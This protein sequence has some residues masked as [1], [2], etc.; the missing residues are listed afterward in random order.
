MTGKQFG[1]KRRRPAIRGSAA[2]MRRA[3]EL[4]IPTAGTWAMVPA[5]AACDRSLGQ[6]TPLHVLT[7][8]AKYRN[9][10]T[11]ECFPSIGRLARDLGVT[12][13]TIQRHLG[14][15]IERGHLLVRERRTANGLSN[16]SNAYLILYNSLAR[17][18]NDGETTTSEEGTTDGVAGGEPHHEKSAETPRHL[19]AAPPDTS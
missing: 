3:E 6:V 2:A 12:R 4:S 5:A 14:A 18:D 10:A 8:L 11:G 19:E 1:G 16:T 9:A 13:R 7:A 17:A 15:L